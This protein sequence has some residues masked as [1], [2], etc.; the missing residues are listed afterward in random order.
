MGHMRFRQI[1][2]V[3]PR[4]ADVEGEIDALVGAPPCFR[5]PAVAKYGLE[6]ALWALGPMFLE[7]VA[8]TQGGTAAER[9]LK[10][11]GDDPLWGGYMAIFDCAAPRLRAVHAEGL[12]VRKIVDHTLGAYTGVQLHPRD[13]RA[14]MIEFNHTVGG[15]ADPDLYAPAGPDWARRPMGSARIASV[16]MTGA[17]DLCA[18]WADIL[19]ASAQS[20]GRDFAAGGERRIAFPEAPL[21]FRAGPVERMEEIVLS[22]VG[23]IAARLPGAK[24]E[25]GAA[26]VAGVRFR[27]A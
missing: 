9:F 5:D 6:N 7:V 26:V 12:G 15:G 2:L 25:N 4:L 10:R 18:H 16:V 23:D 22:G 24:V 27:A 11:A 13:C 17:S 14:A 3:A 1:C 19:Q 20:D 21:V 8:P